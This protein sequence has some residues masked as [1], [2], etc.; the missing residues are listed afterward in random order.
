MSK[1]PIRHCASAG[2]TRAAR[3]RCPVAPLQRDLVK[4]SKVRVIYV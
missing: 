2:A 4:K 3:S 1:I